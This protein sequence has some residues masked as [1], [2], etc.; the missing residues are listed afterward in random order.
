MDEQ[1]TVIVN[2]MNKHRQDKE[3]G[4]N[5]LETLNEQIEEARDLAQQK[6]QMDS[7]LAF[8]QCIQT[9]DKTLRQ[10]QEAIQMQVL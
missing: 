1:E 2:D 3:N 5:E 7:L 8:I 9:R 4:L 10:H 6:D